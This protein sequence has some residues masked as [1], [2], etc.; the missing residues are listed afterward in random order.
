MSRRDQRASDFD[1]RAL[2]TT[3]IECG[4]ELDDGQTP[5]FHARHS[6]GKHVFGAAVRAHRGAAVIDDICS[7][8]EQCCAHFYRRLAHED[9]LVQIAERVMPTE[10]WFGIAESF[11]SVDGRALR[12]SEPL[13]DEEE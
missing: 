10:A 13:L 1:G 6:V 5:R 11:L 12:R 9:E 4:D 8:L 2:R 7:S 3:R